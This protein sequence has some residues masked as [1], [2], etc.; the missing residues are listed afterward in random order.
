MTLKAYDG[1]HASEL[2][3]VPCNCN[4]GQYTAWIGHSAMFII[5]YRSN[6]GIKSALEHISGKF[7][8]WSPWSENFHLKYHIHCIVMYKC[9]SIL[10][11]LFFF[12]WCLHVYVVILTVN[13]FHLALSSQNSSFS[14]S[15]HIL[16][17]FCMTSSL[18]C[19]SHFDLGLPLG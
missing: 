5:F 3:K 6:S 12:L 19:C 1:C 15:S 7:S 8:E 11:H 17:S 2:H 18:T 9:H 16:P 10:Q 14:V 13:S 4:A